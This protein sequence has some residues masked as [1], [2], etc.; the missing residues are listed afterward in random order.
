MKISIRE[1]SVIALF[2][3]LWAFFRCSSKQVTGVGTGSETVIGQVVHRDGKPAGETVVT[4]YPSDYDPVNDYGFLPGIDTTDSNGNYSILLTSSNVTRYTLHAVNLS[5]QTRTVVSDI[6][7]S[8]GDST[9]VDLAELRNTGSIKILLNDSSVDKSGYVFIPGTSYH[10]YVENGCA[11]I[12]SVPAQI[13][14][15]LYYKKNE[16]GDLQSI[17]ENVNVESQVTTVIE[18][19]RQMYSRKIFLN[20]SATG[21]DISGMVTDFPVLLRL[22]ANNFDFSKTK[23]DGSDLRFKKADG[24]T[25]PFEIEMWDLEKS[26]ADIWV[27]VDTVYGNDSTQFIAM[28]WGDAFADGGSDGVTVFDTDA[29]YQGVWHLDDSEEIV[30]DATANGYHGLKQG[31]QELTRGNVGFGQFFRGSGDYSDMGNVCNTDTFSFTVS[32]WI[33]KY[34]ENKIQTIMSKSKGGLPN[35]GYGWLFQ[36]DGDGA[37]QIYLATDTVLWGETGSFVLSSNTHITDS[38]WHHV[39]AVIDRSN[40]ANCRIYNDGTDVS[41]LPSGG[42]IKNIGSIMNSLPLRIGSE[43]DGGYQWEGALD[44]CWISYKAHS[45]EYIKLCFKNQK[46]NDELVIIK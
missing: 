1:T 28:Y 32:A 44:E 37:L 42:N 33:K 23:E 17:S 4:L 10:S 30:K 7:I 27:K 38:S 24:T 41:A 45:S 15:S 11:I 18:N 6:E 43:A 21:A 40:N 12:D 34:G 5:F 16:S 3:F 22:R 35:S 31:S 20:T 13:I 46:C 26:E 14:R 9:F 19:S 8:E 36:L 2:C 25:L 29:G 39:A